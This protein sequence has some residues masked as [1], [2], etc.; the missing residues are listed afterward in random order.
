MQDLAADI[1]N[2]HEERRAWFQ[3]FRADADA[4]RQDRK[5]WVGSLKK[6]WVGFLKKEVKSIRRDNRAWVDS[7]TDDVGA[8]LKE[9]R[10]DVEGARRAWHGLSHT[11]GGRPAEGRAAGKKGGLAKH[12]KAKRRG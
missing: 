11:V 10:S 8:M 5:A 3:A 12:G 4:E 1:V 7:L 6:A 9:V 2:G